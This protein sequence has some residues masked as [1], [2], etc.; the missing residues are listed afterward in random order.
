MWNFS[1]V[2]I[3]R[4]LQS[5]LIYRGIDPNYVEDMPSLQVFDVLAFAEE[6]DMRRDKRLAILIANNLAKTLG[7]KRNR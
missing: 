5:M 2:E 7:R 6:M 4:I 3:D 1:H